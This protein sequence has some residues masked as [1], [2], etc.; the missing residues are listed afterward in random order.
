MKQFLTTTWLILLP[1]TASG[2]TLPQGVGA[3]RLGTRL[4]APISQLFDSNGAKISVADSYSMNFSGPALFRGDAGNDLQLLSQELAKYDGGQIGP[5]TLVDR[6]SLGRLEIDAEASAHGSYL[7]I[8]FAPLDGINIYG[9]APWITVETKTE[10]RIAGQNNARTIRAELGDLTYVEIEN[11]LE[12]AAGLNAS[13][14]ADSIASSGYSGLSGWSY[15]GWGDPI[16]GVTAKM[17]TWHL[18]DSVL[19]IEGD[20]SLGIPIGHTNDPNILTDVDVGNGYWSLTLAGT[21]ERSPTGSYGLY[22]LL[23]AH[24]AINLRTT[25]EM[26]VPTGDEVIVDASRVQLVSLSP[27][28]DLGLKVGGGWKWSVLTALYTLHYNQTLADEITTQDGKRI[29]ALEKDTD[30]ARLDHSVRLALNTYPWY[31]DNVFPIPFI[32]SLDLKQTI[33]GKN[34]YVID[35]IELSLTSFFPTPLMNAN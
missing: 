33:A 8:A 12:Q 29:S 18:S 11:G 27:G 31:A 24:Y 26:R 3:V 32:L 35:Y 13:M 20:A 6:L 23:G 9:G 19:T 21:G 22:S 10:F 30:Q 34:T 2:E 16:V 4:M 25:R 17:T 1:L 15:E 5:G 28:D 14:V 7:G